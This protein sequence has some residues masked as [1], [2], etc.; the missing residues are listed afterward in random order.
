MGSKFFK[1]IL[2]KD[3]EN[4]TSLQGDFLTL[5][6]GIKRTD[7]LTT[8]TP[9]SL[10]GIV[11]ASGKRN[12][13]GFTPQD[14]YNYVM[15]P[16]ALP[17]LPTAIPNGWYGNLL[18]SHIDSVNFNKRKVKD[19][20]EKF[21]ESNSFLD[22]YSTR[23]RY[24]LFNDTSTDYFKHGL[25]IDGRTPIKTAKNNR[26]AWDGSNDMSYRLKT[27][28]NTPFENEDPV[29][30][31]IELIIDANSSPLL[32]GSVEDFIN[33][34]PVISEIQSRRVVIY[35]FKKQFEK[36]FKTK[37]KV[38][39]SSEPATP[40]QSRANNPY[41]SSQTQKNEFRPGRKAYLS[42]YLQK[43]SGLEFLTEAN[44]SGENKPFVDY[45]K[46]KLTLSFYEDV[47]ATMGVI[48]HLY[49]LLYWSRPNGKN[50]VPENL[51]RFN[52]DI[53]VSEVRNF[54]RVRKIVKGSPNKESLE[55]LKDNVSRYIYSLKECQFFFSKMPHDDTVDLS[56][57]KTFGDG[58]GYDVSM[59]FKYATTKFEKWVPD[60][61]LFG[62]YIGYNNGAIWKIG[63]KGGREQ[64]AAETNTEG[65]NTANIVDNS[66]PRFYTQ[67]TNTLRHNGVTTAIR[68]DNIK[69]SYEDDETDDINIGP[70]TGGNSNSGSS[71]GV[72]SNKSLTPISNKKAGTTDEISEDQEIIGAKSTKGTSTS[73]LDQFKENSKKVANNIASSVQNFVVGEINNQILIRA[74][75]LENTITKIKN[76]LGLGG[77][78]GGK[79]NVYP[80]PYTPH[81]FGPWFDVRNELFN[82]VTEDIA[83]LMGRKDPFT[84]SNSLNSFKQPTLG[85]KLDVIYNKNTKYT[86]MNDIKFGGKLSTKDYG[87]LS[88]INDNYSKSLDDVKFGGNISTLNYGNLSNISS[89]YSSPKDNKK[90]IGIKDYNQI[91]FP[92]W[93]QKYPAPIYTGIQPLDR[94]VKNNTQWSFPTI[95][96]KFGKK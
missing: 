85:Q 93:A 32:N 89:K 22:D 68:L 9:V 47:S 31:G 83:G 27:F 81:S 13:P 78:S 42:H 95:D 45:Q 1:N 61:E 52:C 60:A 15:A 4:E 12:Q 84:D 57:I 2:T 14:S 39:Y 79:T 65:G 7:G 40:L 46:D 92:K 63:N 3:N 18:D 50:I 30:F 36:V 41:A 73:G 35:D 16:G 69:L 25:A 34:F 21:N 26:E 86:D 55:I 37:G 48:A 10:V 74:K 80:K 24:L 82:F 70:A 56:S 53:I 77:L 20:A 58:P 75:L 23:D 96:D 49:K 33:T 88:D 51:L 66:T 87:K 44:N 5:A 64:R 11:D 67:G 94:I 17:A 29:M 76:S 8:N 6:N 71:A 62:Q 28:N 43:I 72:G 19:T 54:N 38:F 59:N 91:Q 90:P